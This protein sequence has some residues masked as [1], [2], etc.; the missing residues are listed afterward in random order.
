MK[1]N[2]IFE[3]VGL[4]KIIEYSSFKIDEKYVMEGAGG[5][6]CNILSPHSTQISLI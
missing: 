6:Q 4:G 1:E 5:S 2:G 3:G